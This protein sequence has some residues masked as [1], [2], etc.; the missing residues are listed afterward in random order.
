MARSCLVSLLDETDVSVVSAC[1]RGCFFSGHLQFGY[2]HKNRSKRRMGQFMGACELVNQTIPGFL[3]CIRCDISSNVFVARTDHVL[4]IGGWDPEL[5]V[6]EHRDFFIRLKAAGM[7][8]VVC[9]DISVR[10][11]RPS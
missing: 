6:I 4:E 10:H 7:K 5:V 8:L 1:L 3:S 11:A 9:Q 2:F